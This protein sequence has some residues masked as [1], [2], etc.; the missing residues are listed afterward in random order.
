MI[1]EDL[2][3]WEDTEYFNNLLNP[4]EK[5]ELRDAY[6]QRFIYAS[7]VVNKFTDYTLAISNRVKEILID[8]GCLPNKISV[9]HQIPES[10]DKLKKQHKQ[11]ENNHQVL[12]FAFFGSV[13]PHKGVHKILNASHVLKPG[14]AEF[15]IFGEGNNRY[16]EELKK[17]DTNNSLKWMGS[18]RQEDLSEIAAEMDAAIIPSIWEEGAGLVLLEA[19]ALGLPV[20]ASRIGGIPDFVKHKENGFLYPY[21]SE[22]NLASILTDIISRPKMLEKLSQNTISDISFED[23]MKHIVNIYKLLQQKD[24]PKAKELDFLI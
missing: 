4:S 22:M 9:V 12:K 16:I 10:V 8:F 2:K 23:F 19:Q 24:R 17:A 13:I 7:S 5:S 6:R 18:Y 20:I 3:I 15:Y 14:M 1:R 11:Y 21:N